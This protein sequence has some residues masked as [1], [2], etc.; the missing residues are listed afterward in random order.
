MPPATGSRDSSETEAASGIFT[1]NFGW[2]VINPDSGNQGQFFFKL[3]DRHRYTDTTPHFLGFDTGSIL[4]P[5][6]GYRDYSIRFNELLWQQSLFDRRA[7]VALGKI[8]P[9]NYFNYHPLMVPWTDFLSLGFISS[10][11]INLPDPGWG[12]AVNILPHEHAYIGVVVADPRGDVYEDGEPLYGG[13][14]IWNGDLWSSVEIGL[15]PSFDERF[16]RKLSLMAWHTDEYVDQKG[17]GAVSPSAQGLV[18]TAYWTFDDRFIPVLLAGIADGAGA[19]TLADKHLAAMLGIK[20][21][22]HDVWSFGVNWVE[23]PDSAL[24]D[25]YTFETYYRFHLTEHLALTPDFQAVHH[26][27]LNEA[28]DWLYYAGIR[29]RLT[30]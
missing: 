26:P 16:F 5:G 6:T 3:V 22:S 10:P 15:V 18:G 13:E 24:R 4:L 21:K 14:D 12:A 11:T 20:F 29:A 23:P 8:D 1:F 7:G 9:G 19:N 2:T 27:S 28:Q 30:F 17:E 25:Q